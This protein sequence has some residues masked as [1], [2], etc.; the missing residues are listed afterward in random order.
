MRLFKLHLS[1]LGWFLLSIL[2]C[3]ILLLWVMP[4]IDAATAA[5]YQEISGE[6]RTPVGND[7]TTEETVSY[8]YTSIE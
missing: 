3:G 5:F 1:Y 4:R 8:D 6:G 2:T 7:E